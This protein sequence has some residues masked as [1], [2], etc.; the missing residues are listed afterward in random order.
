MN[1][2]ANTCK[3]N[4]NL[5]IHIHPLLLSLAET[6]NA[7]D[8]NPDI[9]TISENDERA[10]RSD[11][12]ILPN[13]FPSLEIHFSGQNGPSLLSNQNGYFLTLVACCQEC[14][15]P[16]PPQDSIF[17]GCSR[18]YLKHSWSKGS[19]GNTQSQARTGSEGRFMGC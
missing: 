18:Q 9:R 15:A 4:P 3:A 17:R 8:A 7:L 12:Y 19:W 1:F 5:T 16:V 14:M 11:L 6:I 13:A 10:L 2:Y